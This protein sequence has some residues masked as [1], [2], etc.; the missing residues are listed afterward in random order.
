MAGIDRMSAISLRLHLYFGREQIGGATGF[1]VQQDGK[2]FL[3]TN[4]HVLS[5]V[6]PNTNEILDKNLRVPNYVM[7]FH[8]C[9][10]GL[11]VRVQNPEPLLNSNGKRLWFEHPRGKEIDVVALPLQNIPQEAEI[12]PLD[13]SLADVDMAIN[14]AMDVSIIG[15][16]LEF[17]EKNFFAI[18]KTG[19]IAYEPEVDY[20]GKPIFLVDA[21]TRHG[22]SGSVVIKR[23]YEVLTSTT[24][25]RNV[26]TGGS[27]TK[28]LGI[29]SGRVNDFVELGMV[30]KPRA[31]T[32]I[33]D[34]V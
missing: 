14:P 22:M 31:I 32:E 20:D 12:M 10:R 8:N 15:Y 1:I 30:W 21:T 33:L 5:G 34:L 19:H 13:L 17:A 7:I 9:S 18:W 28:F 23:V 4:W 3:I 26:V 2:P 25:Q 27:I 6:N 16:P 24:G 11:D 29:Y